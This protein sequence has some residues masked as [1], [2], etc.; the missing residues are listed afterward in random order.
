MI[1]FSVLTLDLQNTLRELLNESRSFNKNDV[2]VHADLDHS[3]LFWL[4]EL[5]PIPTSEFPAAILKEAR[6]NIKES[7][8]NTLCLAHDFLQTQETGTLQRSPIFLTPVRIHEDKV[9]QRISFEV[10]EE[11]KFINPYVAFLLEEKALSFETIPLEELTS[12]IV[13]AGFDV[14]Q[15]SKRCIGNFHHHRYSVLQELEALLE[16]DTLSVPLKALF[17]ASHQTIALDPLPK[18]NLL[19]ADRDHEAVF[20]A[21]SEHLVVIQGPPGTGKS[22]VL[23]NLAAKFL[24]TQQQT[25]VLS[26]KHVALEVILQ[27]LRAFDLDRLG[28][29]TTSDSDV[30]QLLAELQDNW[31][32]FE[33]TNLATNK[34]QG[35][36]E[37]LENQLQFTL[38]V[39]N[40]PK[41]IGE[42]SLYAFK[43]QLNDLSIDPSFF[44][45]QPP[46][47]PVFLASTEFIQGLYERHLNTHV[48]ILA[49]KTI[50]LPEFHLFDVKL[51]QWIDDLKQLQTLLP[52]DT[53]ESLLE[54]MKQAALCQIL[55]ND[56][57][58]KY[59]TL[60]TPNSKAQ[61]KFLRLRK[62]FL[63]TTKALEALETAPSHWHIAPSKEAF[64]MLVRLSNAR[65]F[66]QRLKWKKQWKRYSQL[67]ISEAASA[68]KQYGEKLAL[69]T[70]KSQIT[71]DF[72][73]LEIENPEIDVEILY[74]SIHQLGEEGWSELSKIP[75]DTRHKI[76]QNHTFISNLYRDLKMHL[77]L[78]NASPVIG[79]LEGLLAQFGLLVSEQSHLKKLDP[80]VLHVLRLAPNFDV[81]RSYIYHSH[82]VRFQQQFPTL[83]TFSMG[84][85]HAKI[86]EIISAQQQEAIHFSK[87]I[88][89]SVQQEFNAYHQLLNTPARKLD[90]AQKALKQILK[91]GKSILVKEFAKTRSHP[92]MRQLMASE[93]RVWIQLL[94]PLWLSNPTQVARSFPMEEGLFDVVIFDEASQIPLQ[95]ALGAL[96]RSKH[97]IIAGDSQQ[98]GPTA[99][100]KSGGAAVLDLLHQASFYWKGCF[101]KHHYRSV[102]PA[103][104]AFSNRHFYEQSLSAYPAYG[105]PFPLTHHLVSNGVFENR[106]NP[107]EA[108]AVVKHILTHLS[109]SDTLGIV[110]FSEEQL[111]CIWETLPANAQQKINERLEAGTVFFKAVE[112]VQGDE[113]DHLIISFGYAKNSEGN[114]DMRFG[115]MNTANG[116]RRLNVLLTR[117]KMR[118]DFF[119]SVSAQ[120]FKLSE[121]ES[122]NL[123][124]LWFV[125]LEGLQEKTSRD[126]P[127]EIETA[128]EGNSLQL[129]APHEHL[130]EARELVTF[131]QVMEA[132]GW[133]V[134][135]R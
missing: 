81:F 130:I 15:S 71:I 128:I 64:D 88:L 3:K 68:L 67:P 82:W 52:F 116:R 38:D 69:N 40:Q 124:R 78:S 55:E 21:V 83:S 42:I 29:I 132:R 44:V 39:L 120:D 108:Q 112:N 84:D 5:T 133:T 72:C 119:S 77:S 131:Q 26:E 134:A 101:L 122:V 115:P 96:Q 87:Q 2:L 31:N 14:D 63:R 117:A 113:C 49:H 62:Q 1:N 74:A 66:S 93:A 8:V 56:L 45:S 23:T 107:N 114:F 111:A 85:L 25:L 94:K 37:L 27:K 32:F 58:K 17:G 16:A 46:S 53:I 73:D 125:H 70:L 104:I 126:W 33:Q 97:G 110:A 7:G 86:S 135:Y 19:P 123:L 24:S 48:G 91:K 6:Q 102:H 106:R 90:E 51:R 13:A 47:I 61:K 89:T 127:F 12:F 121:N 43:E 109:S 54:V 98:M 99:Y 100:F 34:E 129:V 57:Y 76:T 22:Q 20:K 50:H 105:V 30:H 28:Y 10:L 18:N 41:A 118:L 75:L 59:P 4:Q 79:Q 11:K 92:S 9:R 95:N 103:L 60:Y 36:S 35:L 80:D 65:G